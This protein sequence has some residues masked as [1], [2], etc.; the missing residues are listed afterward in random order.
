MQPLLIAEFILY[1]LLS[2]MLPPD[3]II[4]PYLP[5]I[6]IDLPVISTHDHWTQISDILAEIQNLSTKQ[7]N[8]IAIIASFHWSRHADYKT[9]YDSLQYTHMSTCIV[10]SLCAFH[11]YIRIHQRPHAYH[12]PSLPIN[13]M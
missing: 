1:R 2:F 5:I 9:V 10:P 4:L 7:S 8:T 12:V 3:A 6:Q 13:G 11:V